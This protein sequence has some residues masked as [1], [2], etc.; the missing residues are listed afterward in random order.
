MFDLVK[1]I[2]LKLSE[3]GVFNKTISNSEDILLV[4][5]DEIGDYILFR[6]Y[7]SVIKKTEQLKK[8]R[9]VLCGNIIWRDLAVKLDSEFVDEFI[10]LDKKQFTEKF[11]YRYKFLKTIQ[12]REFEKVVNC[13]Y[14]RSYYTNDSIVKHTNSNQKIG[15]VSDLSNSYTWQLHLSSKYYTKLIDSSTEI[16]EFYKNKI[17]FEA[18]INASI[19]Q[20]KPEIIHAKIKSDIQIQHKYAVFFLGGK[21]NYKRWDIRNYIQLGNLLSKQYN[22]LI[23]LT[24]SESESG[25]NQDFLKNIENKK[26]VLDL[27]SKTTLLDLIK[28]VEGSE[29]LVSNDSGIVHIAAAL[30]KEV[31]VIANGTHYGRFLPYPPE[32]AKNLNCFFPKEIEEKMISSKQITYRSEYDINSVPV[33][34]VQEKIDKFIR[35]KLVMFINNLK[36]I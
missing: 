31:F 15:F 22:L 3:P 32:I 23:M 8:Y 30:N 6:N 26:L 34:A 28:L 2:P 27:T 36:S 16:F 9:I 33:E 4:K 5:T 24:G 10:W 18:L 19:D 29:F 7:L 17:L 20:S 13:S 12:K 25:L 35:H 21:R 1:F 11:N 14:S